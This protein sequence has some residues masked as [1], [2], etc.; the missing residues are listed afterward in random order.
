MESPDSC[1]GQMEEC[2]ACHTPNKVVIRVDNI[3]WEPI[4][5]IPQSRTSAY[6]G[7]II[8]PNRYRVCM[9]VIRIKGTSHTL[10]GGIAI[11]NL[12]TEET[13]VMD[14]RYISDGIINRI[15]EEVV[16]WPAEAAS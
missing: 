2:P 4:S 1:V 6:R 11:T 10:A 9:V 15:L 12:N 16:S 5:D 13:R 8:Y 7:F 14:H 3:S